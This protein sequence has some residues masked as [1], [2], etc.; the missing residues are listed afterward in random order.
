M[1]ISE[2][3]TSIQGEG[4]LAGVPSYFVR[5]S[6]CNLRCAWCDTPYA[7]WKPES[8]PMRVEEIV[9]EA[10]RS[11]VSHTVLTGGE[12][13]MFDGLPAL[14]AALRREGMHIT[15]ETAGTID[16]RIE[17]DLMSISPKLASSTPAPGDPRD[18]DGAWRAR[19][20]QRRLNFPVLQGL[21]DAHPTR[22][23]KFVVCG[24]ADLAEIEGVLAGLQGWRPGDVMLM[25]EGVAAP[26][27]DFRT[28]L[29]AECVRRGWRY[30]H[31]LHIELFG[32]T[33]GT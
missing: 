33:R 26:S 21:L 18:P 4:S 25:P 29:A 11:G 9:A 30:C 16:R 32:N 8:R 2:T 12:P 28:W 27:R 6:G 24:P 19:H 5:L 17:C 7:S 15:I 23:L 14:A 13:M 31:R 1:P 10:R 20:E 3:F 22:Q